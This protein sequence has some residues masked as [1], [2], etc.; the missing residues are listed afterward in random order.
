MSNYSLEGSASQ[1]IDSPNDGY[2][3]P[4][5]LFQSTISGELGF[6]RIDISTDYPEIENK[7]FLHLYM[8]YQRQ[9]D[10]STSTV[11]GF[12]VTTSHLYDQSI[13]YQIFYKRTIINNI[14][15]VSHWYSANL[16]LPI[17]K[18]T[19]GKSYINLKLGAQF[20]AKYNISMLIRGGIG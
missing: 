14:N 12:H 11:R 4:P 6:Y 17:I 19:D 1:T 20:G 10:T 3:S 18:H 7:A 15:D 8:K 2:G 16:F 5:P 9:S 13:S